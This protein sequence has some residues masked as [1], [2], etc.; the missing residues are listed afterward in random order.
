MKLNKYW[1]LYLAFIILNVSSCNKNTL[2]AESVGK[3][4]GNYDA[5]AF[6]Y[7]YVEAIKQKL[8]GMVVMH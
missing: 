6:N 7:V 8:M 4:T 2:P 1:F 3:A 5:A